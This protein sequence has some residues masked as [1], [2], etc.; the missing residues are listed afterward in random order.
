MPQTASAS[1]FIPGNGITQHVRLAGSPEAPAILLIHGLGWSSHL[2]DRQAAW[3]ADA[4]WRVVAPDLRGMGDSDKPAAPYSIDQFTA[5]MVALLHALDI[6]AATVVGFSLG[7]TIAMAL[8]A[9]YP[10]LV[11]GLVVVCASASSSTDAAAA[12]EAMLARAARTGPQAFAAEQATAIFSR[13]WALSHPDM[14][15]DFIDRRAAMD[16]AAL[17]GAFRAA[18]G[19]DLRDAIA[20]I[21]V[22]ARVIVSDEDAFVSVDTGRDIARRLRGDFVLVADAGHMVSVEQPDAFDATLRQFLEAN[23]ADRRADVR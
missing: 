15:S 21:R 17:A 12:T 4:G 8:A 18:Y 7:G 20:S 5:D 13:S 9:R 6:A 10:A 14:V 3:L 19:V 2:W 1:R 16:Q 22:P 11:N 23:T